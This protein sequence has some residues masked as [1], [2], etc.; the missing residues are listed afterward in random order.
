M[1]N[2]AERPFRCFDIVSDIPIIVNQEFKAKVP[3]AL[4]LALQLAKRV[5]RS[6]Y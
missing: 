1:Q 2:C 4:E 3:D 5:Q 6:D